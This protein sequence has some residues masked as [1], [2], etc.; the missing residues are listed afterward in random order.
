MTDYS[1]YMMKWAKDLYPYAR[2]LISNENTKTLNYII[3]KIGKSKLI[4]FKSGTKVYDWVIPNQWEIFDSFIEDENGKKFAEFKNNNLHIVYNSHKIDKWVD[5]KTLKKHISYLENQPNRIPYCTSYYKKTWGFS[6]SKNEFKKLNKKKY[7]VFIDSIS[8]KGNLEICEKIIKGKN[9]K[10]ILFSTYICHPSMVN[11]NLSGIVLQMA[12]IKYIKEKYKKTN[13]SYRFVFLPETIGSIAY[14]N[15]NIKILKK[16]I[17]AGF[18]LSCVG[19]EKNYSMISSRREDTISD[20]ILS[21]ALISKKNFKKYS[22]LFRGSDERQYCYPGVDLP[23]VSF[24]RSKFHEFKEYHTDADNFKLVTKKGLAGSFD[25]FKTII[26]TLET[27]PLFPKVNYICEPNLGKRNLLSTFGKKDN[28]K[29]KLLKNIL[30]YC[31]GKNNIFEISKLLKINI[32]LISEQIA[33][34]KKNK[35]IK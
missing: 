33:I 5:I 18:N 27:N 7:R 28:F 10:E 19:D 25:V 22:Y 26:D 4:L 20:D 12:I 1:N 17:F 13:Y 6:L 32:K 15:K 8:K 29:N 14:I 30:V 35:L 21:S 9:S 23:I 11:D 16:N 2:T 34:L 31:D 24:C 3:D